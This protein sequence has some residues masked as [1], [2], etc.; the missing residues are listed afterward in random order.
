MASHKCTKSRFELVVVPD[1][2]RRNGIKTESLTR[3]I[4]QES[5]LV[6]M[7]VSLSSSS[8]TPHALFI[9]VMVLELLDE[10]L[11]GFH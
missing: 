6:L 3:S 2:R 5:F 10:H 11:E 1:K 9:S 7:R 4:Q 8:L